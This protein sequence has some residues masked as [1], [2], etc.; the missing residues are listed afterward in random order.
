MRMLCKHCSKSKSSIPFLQFTPSSSIPCMHTLPV[1]VPSPDRHQNSTFGQS[2]QFLACPGHLVAT[3][4]THREHRQYRIC[5][6]QCM[7]PVALSPNPYTQ[8]NVV[9]AMSPLRL[10]FL[11]PL[12]H[13]LLRSLHTATLAQADLVNLLFSIIRLDSTQPQ[14]STQHHRHR[15]LCPNK[16]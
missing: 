15:C 9:L 3:H 5:R 2:L 8:L 14:S 10:Q 7:S 16:M 12:P 13:H 6:L 1:V 11:S 4:Q